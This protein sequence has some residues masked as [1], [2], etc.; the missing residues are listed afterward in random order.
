MSHSILKL[1]QPVLV[2]IYKWQAP[3]EFYVLNMSWLGFEP[4]CYC[5]W[6]GCA[7]HSATGMVLLFIISS[8]KKEK[9]DKQTHCIEAVADALMSGGV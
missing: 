1:S 2:L 9:G 6:D 7:N 4:Q 5:V 3:D 8:N